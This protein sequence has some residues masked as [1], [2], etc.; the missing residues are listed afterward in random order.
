MH[1]VGAGKAAGEDKA[2]RLPRA[3]EG[4][5]AAVAEEAVGERRRCG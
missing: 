2:A 4:P 1:K 3:A 5:G